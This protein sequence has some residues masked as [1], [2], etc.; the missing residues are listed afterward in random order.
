[1]LLQPSL[2]FP[3]P[4][5]ATCVSLGL[6]SYGLVGV[7][8]ERGQR[9]RVACFKLPASAQGHIGASTVFDV[10][11]CCAWVGIPTTKVVDLFPVRYNFLM[12]LQFYLPVLYYT[13]HPV[14]L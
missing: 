11:N 12:N 6:A 3:P 13:V 9:A 1:M 2:V 4:G 5:Y 10:Y 14:H 8:R 7:Q